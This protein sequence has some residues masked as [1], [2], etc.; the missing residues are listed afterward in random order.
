LAQPWPVL[1]AEAFDGRLYV[2]QGTSGTGYEDPPT[3]EKPATHLRLTIYDLAGLPLLPVLGETEVT[4]EGESWQSEFQMIWPRRGVL[5][6]AGG[7]SQYWYPWLDWR[8]GGIAGDVAFPGGLAP[9]YWGSNEGR[10]LAFSVEDVNAPEFV[11]EVDLTTNG[12]WSFSKASVAAGLV[13]LTH[14][15]AEPAPPLVT[16]DNTND[17][18]STNEPPDW[19]WVQRS[20]LDVIDYGDPREP[21]V[22]RPIETSGGLAGVSSNGAVVY[23]VGARWQPDDDWSNDSTEWLDA[24]AYDGVSLHVVDSLELPASWPRPLLVDQDLI[25]LGRVNPDGSG[26]GALETWVLDGKG[27][28]V[29]SQSLK[30]EN[31]A[32][33]LLSVDGLVAVQ[34]SA[35]ILCYEPMES[36]GLRQVGSGAPSGCVWPELRHAVADPERAMWIPLG[37]NGVWQIPLGSTF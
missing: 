26:D 6:L 24:S 35:E 36:A 22:R 10:L 5:V 20:F 12:W 30:L 14:T 3:P 33:T 16:Q 19:L 15:T 18:W 27:S 29:L 9:Y 25:L 4:W 31:A 1:S 11:S 17:G 2:V 8:V 32:H 7:V 37:Y 23:T 28:L 34:N 21:V 13:Y